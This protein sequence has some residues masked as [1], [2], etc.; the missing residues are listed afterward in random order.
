MQIKLNGKGGVQNESPDVKKQKATV[1]L[2]DNID[3]GD[4]GEMFRRASPSEVVEPLNAPHSLHWAENHLY[5][6]LIAEAKLRR[7]RLTA[8]SQPVTDLNSNQPMRF[9]SAPNTDVLFGVSP[10]DLIQIHPNGVVYRP[11]P[12]PALVPACSPYVGGGTLPAGLYHLAFAYQDLVS[13]EIGGTTETTSLAIDEN[14]GIHIDGSS[15]IAPPQDGLVL[16]AFCSEAFGSVLWKAINLFA[17]FSAVITNRPTGAPCVTRDMTPMPFGKFVEYVGGR[18]C[19]A[20]DDGIFYSEPFHPLSTRPTTNWI[21]ISGKIRFMMR[22]GDVLFYGDDRGAMS[23]D[24]IGTP[25]MKQQNVALDP[26]LFNSA[27]VLSTGSTLGSADR[28]N[29]ADQ[30]TL[31]WLGSRGAYVGLPSGLATKVH[32]NL[33]MDNATLVTSAAEVVNRELRHIVFITDSRAFQ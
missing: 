14:G 31:L 7:T 32:S 24:N 9:T 20:N 23:I 3:V 1:E 21:T 11:I 27:V 18:L 25:A 8:P 30:P 28:G 17:G 10:T 16:I 29:P 15:I 26:P 6:Y 2:M 19:V 4:Q 5:A 22:A 33:S 12:V 13:G